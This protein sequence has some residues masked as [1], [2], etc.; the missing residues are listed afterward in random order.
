MIKENAF[1]GDTKLLAMH[2]ELCA[3][4]QDFDHKKPADKWKSHRRK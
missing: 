3:M 2:R 4:N 1:I